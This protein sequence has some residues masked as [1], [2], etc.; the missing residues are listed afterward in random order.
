MKKKTISSAKQYSL[1][2]LPIAVAVGGWATAHGG[3]PSTNVENYQKLLHAV[4]N[5]KSIYVKSD[6]AACKVH[7]TNNPG[8]SV[9]GIQHFENFMLKA[10]KSIAF[11][12]THFTVR[13]DNTAVNEFLSFVVSADGVVAVRNKFL[14]SS[15][16]KVLRES[17]FDCQLDQG[18]TIRW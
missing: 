2:L 5:G 17:D 9:I 4:M 16:N 12:T 6:L 15:T 11:S 18:V 1:Y 14:D 3:A 7:G 10:D 13:S 8:P